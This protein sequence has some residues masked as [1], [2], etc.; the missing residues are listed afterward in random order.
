MRKLIFIILIILVGCNSVEV[1]KHPDASMLILEASGDARVA[2][3]KGGKLIEYGWVDMA[4]LKG[5]TIHKFN[6]SEVLNGE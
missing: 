1:V 3:Y 5:W 2:V 4:E 6:W